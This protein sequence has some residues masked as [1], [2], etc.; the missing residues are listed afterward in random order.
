MPI[1]PALLLLPPARPILAAP[2][3]PVPC[4]P[5]PQ[6]TRQDMGPPLRAQLYYRRH[7]EYPPS[8]IRSQY[9]HTFKTS[10][11]HPHAAHTHTCAAAADRAR[12]YPPAS[13]PT[14]QRG[15][16]QE[17]AEGGR[18]S[19]VIGPPA[20]AAPGAKAFKSLSYTSH[21]SHHPMPPMQRE[22]KKGGWKGGA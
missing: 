19:H 10:C 21:L 9:R 12:R 8:Y 5:S 14:Y 17:Q 2:P 20:G 18:A 1:R 11:K 4:C 3:R 7:Q 22:T 13:E 6:D 16:L 15:N